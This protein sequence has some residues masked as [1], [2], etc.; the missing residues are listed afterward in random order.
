[1][2]LFCAAGSNQPLSGLAPQISV[3]ATAPVSRESPDRTPVNHP[4]DT[5]PAPALPEEEEEDVTDQENNWDDW[6][7][8]DVGLLGRHRCRFIGEAGETSM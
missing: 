7:D 3:E 2:C 4:V 8:I 1:M 6:G 5:S